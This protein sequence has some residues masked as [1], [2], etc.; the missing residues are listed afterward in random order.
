MKKLISAILCFTAL[1][2]FAGCKTKTLLPDAM[3]LPT[4]TATADPFESG[5]ISDGIFV[6]KYANI[7]ITP[8]SGEWTF[9]SD[10]EIL[11]LMNI[12]LESDILTDELK[13][14]A[15]LIKQRTVYDCV[16]KKDNGSNLIVMYENLQG[17]EEIDG[18][19]YLELAKTQFASLGVGTAGN[20]TEELL[21]GENYYRLDT[22]T[23]YSGVTMDQTYLCRKIDSRVLIIILTGVPADGKE[24]NSMISMISAQ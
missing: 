2:A 11:K 18:R 14:T 24:I 15:A 5:K 19:A 8:P 1:C 13:K 6:S 21:A 20:I 4:S 12:A 22:V 16:L 9:A 3:P 10:E 23:E 7:K 17:T